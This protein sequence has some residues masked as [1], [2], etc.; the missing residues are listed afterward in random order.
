[1][2]TGQLHQVNLWL[3]VARHSIN[4]VYIE[5]LINFVQLFVPKMHQ[6]LQEWKS[7]LPDCCVGWTEIISLVFK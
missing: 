6:C 1:M 2:L 4:S 7:S 5:A 3:H